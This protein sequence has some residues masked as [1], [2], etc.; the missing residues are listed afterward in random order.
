MKWATLS[1]FLERCIAGV[2][3]VFVRIVRAF[4]EGHYEDPTA[5]VGVVGV[6]GV[7]KV[8]VEEKRVSCLHLHIH[9][10]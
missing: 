6:R 1:Y 10:F 4:I 8:T 7:Q 5:T 3:M 9:A 2:V